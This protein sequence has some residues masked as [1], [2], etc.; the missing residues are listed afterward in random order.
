MGRHRVPIL[1]GTVMACSRRHE[2]FHLWRQPAV[3]AV[4]VARLADGMRSSPSR[5]GFFS[6]GQ[7]RANGSARIYPAAVRSFFGFVAHCTPMRWF[8][9]QGRGFSLRASFGN[10]R[11]DV[12]SDFNSKKL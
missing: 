4:H 1:M 3:T 12:A 2:G 9:D 7:E 10:K 8:R 6:A 11:R 5:R